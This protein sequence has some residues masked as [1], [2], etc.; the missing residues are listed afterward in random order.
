MPLLKA[1][2]K[3]IKAVI[4]AA[5]Y[6]TRLYPLTLNIPKPL[7][8]ITKDK[9]VIDFIADDLEAS[10]IIDEIIVVT[11]HKFYRDFLT[12]A[13]GRK[14]KVKLAVLDDATRSN[15]DRLGAVGDISFA[16]AKK[17]ITGDFIIIGGDNLFDRGLRTFLK[18][19][20]ERILFPSMALYDVKSKNEAVRFGIVELDKKAK[21]VGFEEKPPKP[22]STLAAT[23]L[24]YFPSRT[25]VLLRKY[26]TDRTTSKD[27]P[28]NY[29]KWLL[30][31]TEV[32]G[33]T[34]RQ[35]H[36]Y[37]IGHFN[38]YKEVVAQFNR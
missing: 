13:H 34:L 37:D 23:C 38:F 2:P 27:A 30:G 20:H 8:K 6:A 17:R 31:Q 16:V 32:Y 36:W 9:T 35:G 14:K 7:L 25:L 18:F 11:N 22:K 15:E 10:G 26:M 3:K 12:W 29:I 19:A 21:I 33:C 5:G 4:L 28:G 24:Y 1:E